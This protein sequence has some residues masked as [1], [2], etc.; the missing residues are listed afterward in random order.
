[1]L[2]HHG[3]TASDRNIAIRILTEVSYYRLSAYGLAIRDRASGK[4]HQGVTIDDLYS[5]YR[6][7][8]LLRHQ[9]LTAIEGIEVKLRSVISNQLALHYGAEGY[10]C[11]ANFTGHTNQHGELLHSRAVR[12]LDEEIKRQKAHPIVQHHQN[13]YGGHF[14][15]WVALEFVSFGTLSTLYSAMKNEDRRVIAAEY[16]VS[17]THLESWI[18]SLVEIRNICAHYGRLYQRKLTKAPRLYKE[19]ASF[20]SGYVFP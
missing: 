2:Q 18:I 4:Y 8:V 11:E 6:F 12:L 15:V 10:R 20:K 13:K 1:M 16:G 3:L 14:P 19:H 9:L 7:D 17:A 5:I